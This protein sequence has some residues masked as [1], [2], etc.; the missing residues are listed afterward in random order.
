MKKQT[1]EANMFP[2]FL[3]FFDIEVKVLE[4]NVF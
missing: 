1:G 4:I 2:V 3:T